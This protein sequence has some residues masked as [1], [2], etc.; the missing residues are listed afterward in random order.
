MTGCSTLSF[1]VPAWRRARLLAPL[2]D[3]A[4]SGVVQPVHWGT[5]PRADGAGGAFVI[6]MTRPAGAPL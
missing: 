5:L 3:A 1:R 2:R 6:V 4:I